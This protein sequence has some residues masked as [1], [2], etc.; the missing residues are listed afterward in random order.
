MSVNSFY[1]YRLS[2]KQQMSIFYFYLS[3]SYLLVNNLLYAAMLW[4]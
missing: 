1:F 2:I 4:G 3:K